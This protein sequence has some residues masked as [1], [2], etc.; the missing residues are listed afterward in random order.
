M[1]GPSLD[2]KHI[3]PR[4]DGVLRAVRPRLIPAHRQAAGTTRGVHRSG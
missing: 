2:F 4:A 3:V 1:R